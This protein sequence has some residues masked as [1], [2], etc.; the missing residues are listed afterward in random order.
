MNAEQSTCAPSGKPQHWDQNDWDRCGWLVRRLPARIVKATREGRWG[1]VQAL[2][3]WLTHSF[4]GNGREPGDGRTVV[5]G[6][7]CSRRA[8]PRLEPYAPK[9]SSTVPRGGGG[10]KA[11]L[12]PEKPQR[13]AQS[14][15]DVRRVLGIAESLEAPLE[16][17]QHPARKAAPRLVIGRPLVTGELV[18]QDMGK[19]PA[20]GNETASQ[21]G[22]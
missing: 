5:K 2:P 6:W 12:L 8:L 15:A 17:G 21:A 4:S 13:V 10:R 20:E 11:I 3:R 16:L 22:G 14:S 18:G 19:L 1:K 9:G 7:S